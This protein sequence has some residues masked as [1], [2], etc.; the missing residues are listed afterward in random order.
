MSE[1]EVAV[2]VELDGTPVRVG[3]LFARVTRGRQSASFL[4]DEAWLRHPRRF[5]LDPVYL[6]L[7]PGTFHTSDRGALFPGLADSAPDRWGRLLM[8]RRARLTGE[9]RTLFEIDF[10]LGVHDA[11]R[12]GAIRLRDSAGGAF[13][14]A[15][16]KPIPPLVRLGRLLTAS[17]RVQRDPADEE[18]LRVLLAPGSS[19]GGARPK[20][21]VLDHDGQLLI[22]KFPAVQD[23]WPVTTWEHVTCRLATQAGLRCQQTRLVS[24]G[25]EPVL[26]SRR[27]D[28]RA[29]RRVPFLS[30]MA[31]VGAEDRE[32]EHSYLEI[33]DA[34]RRHGIAAE[35]ELEELWRRMV[36]NVLVTNTDDHLRNHGFLFQ[37]D[38]WA[39]SPA[40]DL[41]PMPEDVRPRVHALALDDRNPRSSL[42][43]VL[44]EASYFG[45]APQRAENLARALGEVTRRWRAVA[46]SNGLNASEVERMASA[47][48]HADLAHALRLPGP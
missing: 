3:T 48:E 47:F 33:A 43:T 42:E 45:L 28:R 38:A 11:V 46:R 14:A 39:L 23:E 20:A 27:F 41:N 15:S 10:L 36:F 22:A 35:A 29:E 30:A 26:L 44:E 31:M 37:G 17:D 24:V 16:E 19:L 8:T 12:Q 2:F 40:Y 32:A 9:R 4:Y 18:A 1:R 7:G 25:G 5:A 34:I 21:S 6:P 13:L